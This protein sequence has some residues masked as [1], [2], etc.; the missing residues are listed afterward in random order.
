VS[1]E[2]PRETGSGDWDRFRRF[3]DFFKTSHRF[4]IQTLVFITLNTSLNT[5]TGV[6]VHQVFQM[7]TTDDELSDGIGDLWGGDDIGS[8]IDE[9]D[10][11]DDMKEYPFVPP[12]LVR[13]EE[14]ELEETSRCALVQN[15]TEEKFKTGRKSVVIGWISYD[16]CKPLTV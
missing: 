10:T 16:W 5:W 7:Y 13:K 1:G 8:C 4:R 12:S 15:H 14:G 6:Y 9:D 3:K 11:D 2:P